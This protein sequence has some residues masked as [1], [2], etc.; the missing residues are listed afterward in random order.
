MEMK[1]I[2]AFGLLLDVIGASILA[3][4]TMPKKLRKLFG[5]AQLPK[6][7]EEK[8]EQVEQL[9]R[10]WT[11]SVRLILAGFALQLFGTVFG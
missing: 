5:D 6:N 3:R 1:Y 10:S 9:K 2:V 11:W 7:K 8:N 4:L